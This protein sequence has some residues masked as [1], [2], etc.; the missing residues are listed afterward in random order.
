LKGE[1]IPWAIIVEDFIFLRK[2]L[3]FQLKEGASGGPA[4]RLIDI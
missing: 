2:G 4:L 3:D 1:G